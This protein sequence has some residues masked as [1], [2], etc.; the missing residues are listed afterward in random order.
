[1][2]FGMDSCDFIIIYRHRFVPSSHAFFFVVVGSFGS[3][4]GGFLDFCWSLA[5]FLLLLLALGVWWEWVW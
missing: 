4:L 2:P 1:M 5:F 3:R